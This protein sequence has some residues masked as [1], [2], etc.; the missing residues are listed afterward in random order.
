[1]K[2]RR[3][4]REVDELLHQS[5]RGIIRRPSI[6]GAEWVQGSYSVRLGPAPAPYF[7]KLDRKGGGK[8]PVYYF[9]DDDLPATI[10]ARILDHFL[11]RR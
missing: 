4:Y 6:S 8:K 5:P 1:M 3:L 10:T 11:K 9:D 2:Y 7:V